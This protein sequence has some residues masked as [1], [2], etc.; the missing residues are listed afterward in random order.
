MTQLVCWNCGEDLAD[1]PLPISRQASCPKCFNELHCCRLC[2]HYDA[3]ASTTC[4]EDRADTPLQKENSNFCEFFTP[5]L[6]VFNRQTIQRSTNAQTD[7]DGLFA[8]S[9]D[10]SEN[11]P[12]QQ[13]EQQSEDKFTK[14]TEEQAKNKL[15]NL[16]N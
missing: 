7:L 9:V 14:T 16:F 3:R 15:D 11:P 8:N 2:Q 12:S 10:N 1:I 6:G 4:F 13:S 5:Q